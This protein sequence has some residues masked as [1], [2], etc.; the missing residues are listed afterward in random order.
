M[1]KIITI[2]IFSALLTIGIYFYTKDENKDLNIEVEEVKAKVEEYYVYGTKLNI[3]GTIPIV[4]YQDMKL[5]INNQKE[6][7]I[8]LDTNKEKDYTTFQISK[9]INNGLYLDNIESGKNYIF[10]K[11]INNNSETKYY[12]L[13]NN[14]KYD[15]ID[16]YTLSKYNNYILIDYQNDY[17]TLNLKVTK[18]KNKDVYDITIDA[19]HGG[20]D[21]GATGNGYYEKNIT[22]DVALSLQ[23]QLKNKGLK[24]A[25]TRKEDT[26]LEEYNI[27]NNIGRAVL[28]N[29][30]NSK[31][32]FSIHLNSHVNKNMN[33]L[34]ILTPP[35]IDY[36]FAKTLAKNIVT[37]TNT[38]Y[39]N[40]LGFKMYNGVYTRIIDQK[41]IDSRNENSNIPYDIKIG[42]SYYYILR[43]TGAYMTGAYVNGKDEEVGTNPYYNSNKGVESYIIELGY[44]INKNDIENI[45]NNQKL[46]VN[47]IADTIVSEL[48]K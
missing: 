48:I 4:E 31:Y 18:N 19:G 9:E 1:K 28:P 39:S 15:H 3:K 7:E 20:K 40:N 14:T 13:E 6:T 12:S 16:Y 25:I 22:L 26:T 47:A 23:C 29:H 35:N 30:N 38:N 46:Y 44:I 33:G 37:N 32:L 43:E 21:S 41:E 11:V 36:T 17:N 10:L 8:N 42:A 5:V 24:V 27:K 2:I 34:E 45:V